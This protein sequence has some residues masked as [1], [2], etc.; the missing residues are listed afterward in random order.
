MD[1]ARLTRAAEK[2]PGGKILLQSH[3]WCLKNYVRLWD[4]NGIEQNRNTP[5]NGK[6]FRASSVLSYTFILLVIL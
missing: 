6:G 4:R 5:Y 2:E 1:F 3:P